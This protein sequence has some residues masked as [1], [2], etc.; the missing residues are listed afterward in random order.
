[1]AARPARTLRP[2][3]LLRAVTYPHP[4]VTSFRYRGHLI[5]AL[6]TPGHADFGGEVERV[7]SMVDGAVLLV[8]AVEG[9]RGLV[10]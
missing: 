2:I 1:V 8:D 6:D 7:L 9:E 3:S 10:P 5:N 4:Q